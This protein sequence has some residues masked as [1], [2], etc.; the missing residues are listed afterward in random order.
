MTNIQNSKHWNFLGFWCLEFIQDLVLFISNPAQGTRF[1]IMQKLV[2][3]RG[4]FVSDM[5]ERYRFLL[6]EQCI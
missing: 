6:T 4:Y 2:P 3:P 1:L 5:V